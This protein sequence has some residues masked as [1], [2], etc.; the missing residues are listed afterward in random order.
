MILKY[1]KAG[2]KCYSTLDSQLAIC[3]MSKY[4]MQILLLLHDKAAWQNNVATGSDRYN[5]RKNPYK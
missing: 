5:N 3:H 2:A 1:I 4:Q